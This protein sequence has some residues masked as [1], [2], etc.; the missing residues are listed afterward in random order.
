MPR[1][2]LSGLF[3]LVQDDDVLGMFAMTDP[4]DAAVAAAD[5]IRQRLD[6]VDQR[7][8]AWFHPFGWTIPAGSVDEG[9]ATR[10]P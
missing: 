7:V 5:P 3:D 6:V 2:A 1:S 10:L 9:P 4:G 8:E